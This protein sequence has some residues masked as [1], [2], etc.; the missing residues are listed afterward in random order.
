MNLWLPGRK[1]RGRIVWEFGIGTLLYLK[2]I[3]NKDLLYSTGNS[4]QYSVITKKGEKLKKDTGIGITKS[5]YC[6]S[7]SNISLLIN[8]SPI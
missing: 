3:T 7:V 8:F 4:A 6:T 1:G 2:Y 5:L